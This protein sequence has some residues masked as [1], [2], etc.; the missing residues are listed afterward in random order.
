MALNYTVGDF[1]A[2][3]Q[4]LGNVTETDGVPDGVTDSVT[5]NQ[6]PVEETT[7]PATTTTTKVSAT[8]LV[9]NFKIL[10]KCTL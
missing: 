6:Q 1:N 4:A 5:G 8:V 3:T 9:I 10:L 2:T 7:V